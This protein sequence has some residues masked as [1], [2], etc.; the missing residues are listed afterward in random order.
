MHLVTQRLWRRCTM[1]WMFF[2]C[3]LVQHPLCS[4]WIKEQFWFSS[5][6]KKCI[7]EGYGCH[8]QWFIP[9]KDLSKVRWKLS[10]KDLRMYH[11]RCHWEQSWCM[12]RGQHININRSLEEGSSNPHGWDWIFEG[13]QTS[14][15]RVTAYEV[16]IS[17]RIRSRAWRCDWVAAVSWSNFSGWEASSS[18]WAKKVVPWDGKYSWWRCCEDYWKD[19][20]GFRMWHRLSWLS[21]S[22]VWEGWFQVWKKFYCRY[23]FI[24]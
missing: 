19:D 16:E 17:T 14:V 6:S 21:N 5:L 15:G 2:S 4:P 12:G 11:S 7:S 18:G 9:L 13:F 3:L 23:N 10:G 20:K 22:R 1:R 8:R 24:K